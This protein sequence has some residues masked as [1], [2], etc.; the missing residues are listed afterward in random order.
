MGTIFFV[1]F[2]VANWLLANAIDKYQ[3]LV[4]GAQYTIKLVRRRLT[5][6]ITVRVKANSVDEA[7]RFVMN[8]SPFIRVYSEKYG[9][10]E[11]FYAFNYR[12]LQHVAAF[13][14]SSDYIPASLLVTPTY[15]GSALVST[16]QNL[17]VYTIRER[18][19]LFNSLVADGL[20]QDRA[21]ELAME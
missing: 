6:A 1:K 11:F 10:H 12:T 3:W 19:C 15:D 16:Y 4:D 5:T 13:K 18:Y 20:S 8:R 17:P 14:S 9:R 2:V 21:A 7:V